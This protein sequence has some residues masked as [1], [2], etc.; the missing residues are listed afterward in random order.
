MKSANVYFTGTGVVPGIAIGRAFVI[1]KKTVSL[2]LRHIEPHEVEFEIKRFEA[3]VD[4][5]FNHLESIKEKIDSQY[6]DPGHIIE[7][8][9]MMLRDDEL[10]NSVI[11]TISEKMVNVEWALNM[12]L[13]KWE[14]LFAGVEDDYLRERF[15]DIHH[16]INNLQ[17]QLSGDG[18]LRFDPPPDAIVVAD[19][20][21]AAETIQLGRS[22]ISALITQRGGRTSHSV[23]I[24][25]AF[26]I[27]TIVGVKSI[28]EVVGTGDLLLVDGLEGVVIINPDVK[29][30]QEYRLRMH[31]NF[32]R[33]QS[34]ISESAEP[35]VTIDNRTLHIFANV[36][37]VD[38]VEA[39]Q[40]HGAE[41][42]GLY[43][44]EFL[45]ISNIKRAM[46]E[47]LHYLDAKLLMERW[48][49]GAVTIR[50]F[51]L[52]SDKYA[53]GENPQKETNP[54]LGLR[55]IRL[56]LV[57][58]TMF[59]RQIRGILRASVHCPDV[60]LR[61][62]FPLISSFEELMMAK[63]VYYEAYQE[64][65]TE[66]HELPDN[67]RLGSMIELPSAAMQ[68][69]ALATECDFF[70]IGSNDLIQYSLAVDRNN[71]TVSHLYNPLNPGVLKMIRNVIQSG[72]A[73]GI[74]VAICGDMATE[75]ISALLLM[76]MGLKVFSMPPSS[77]PHIKR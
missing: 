75:P 65:E 45:F 73:A 44:T 71:D 14:N 35:A 17:R 2:S 23:I 15:S 20:A 8:Q 19:E 27:P 62:M 63:E 18:C 76:G 48:G 29:L 4:K 11:A 77:I 31:K 7:A 46:D 33:E 52:G 55:S 49:H 64:L 57:N 40:S 56:S 6:R 58:R 22:A 39:A 13:E 67:I 32:A 9:Q 3:A 47:E 5:I 38:E 43:R 53:L 24:A 60:K 12:A 68:A 37:F 59:K 10:H 42:I 69:D 72:E 66:G 50:T 61:I 26:E 51:D 16:L 74:P 70:S 25:K 21:S 36:D 28:T 34:L 30:V 1:S 41:G 54:A